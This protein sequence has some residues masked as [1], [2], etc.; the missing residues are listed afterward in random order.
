MEGDSRCFKFLRIARKC[1]LESSAP[2]KLGAALAKSGRLISFGHNKYNMS[3]WVARKYFKFASV[4]AECDAIRKAFSS[5]LRGA[6]L[7]IVRLKRNG[8]YGFSK[9]CVRCLRV[10]QECGIKRM[11][12]ST[13]QS[14]FY[15]EEKV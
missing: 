1:A 11:V 15:I 7:Y 5:D 6:V 2:F 8:S 14:P 12:Y 4:H 9:P 10:L 13:E 3:S